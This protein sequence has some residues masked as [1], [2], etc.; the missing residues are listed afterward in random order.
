MEKWEESVSDLTNKGSALGCEESV[1]T[2]RLTNMFDKKV[3]SY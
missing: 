1:S 2:L 3:I